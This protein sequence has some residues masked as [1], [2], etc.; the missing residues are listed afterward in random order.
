V[1]LA[2]AFVLLPGTAVRIALVVAAAAT[3]WLDG[4][5][6]RTRGPASAAGALIDPVTDKIF[7]ISALIG[8]V[9]SGVMT[10]TQLAVMLARDVF[11]A[12][13]ALAV[14]AMRLPVRLRARFPGK[15]LTNIQIAAVIVL[16]L[17]PQAA[18]VVVAIA[19]IVSIWAIIDYAALGLRSLRQRATQG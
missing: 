16:L 15:L 6:A 13:G 18:S 7:L 19:G 11:V 4:W 10:T 5:W 1:P 14:F 2:V 12:A 8:F 17:A 3:D 9:T